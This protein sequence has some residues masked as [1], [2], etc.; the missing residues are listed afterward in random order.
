MLAQ[1]QEILDLQHRQNKPVA[2][3][4]MAFPQGSVNNFVVG[5]EEGNVYSGMG[6]AMKLRL[7]IKGLDGNELIFT[8]VVFA[9]QLADMGRKRG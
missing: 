9:L 3:T 7:S 2:A 8:C 1:P 5:S 4:C 6:L